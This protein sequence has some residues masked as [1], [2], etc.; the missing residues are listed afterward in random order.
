MG[1]MTFP[2]VRH[3]VAVVTRTGNRINIAEGSYW[4]LA[5]PTGEVLATWL[6]ADGERV[7]QPKWRITKLIMDGDDEE[8]DFGFA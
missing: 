8:E 3:V 1:D 6:N 5:S 4:Q 7:M 2:P